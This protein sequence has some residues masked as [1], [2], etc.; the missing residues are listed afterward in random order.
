MALIWLEFIVVSGLIVLFGYRLSKYGDVIAEKT[1]LG[2][3]WVGTIFIALT[4]TLP[5]VVVSIA[6]A[7]I[8]AIELALANLFG[9][10]MFNV[11]IIALDDVFYRPGLI[12][13]AASIN[14]AITGLFAIVMASLVIAG[15]NYPRK[16]ISRTNLSWET[17]TILVLF[18]ANGLVLYFLGAE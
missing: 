7:R 12:L 9:S 13:E 14:N 11:G 4:T 3:I 17:A 10:N 2:R 15:L 5:E 6:A 16:R 18:I 8:G 1:G